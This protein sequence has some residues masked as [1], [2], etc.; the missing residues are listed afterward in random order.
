MLLIALMFQLILWWVGLLAQSLGWQKHFQAN[1][2]RSRNVL[3]INRL[4]KEV[5]RH[6]SYQLTKQDLLKGA[7][8]FIKEVR[9]NG[10]AM[11]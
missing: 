9:K 8:L 7:V 6:K 3:S 11:A 2:V 1:T 5:L 10:D 4:G